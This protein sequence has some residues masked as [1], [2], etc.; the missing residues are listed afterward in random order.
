MK[1][2][3]PLRAIVALFVTFAVI[4]SVITAYFVREDI[5][6]INTQTL[7]KLS[8]ISKLIDDNYLYAVDDE[9]IANSLISGYVDGID[10]KYASYFDES[11]SATHNEKLKGESYGI[12]IMCV[13]EEYGDIF[14]WRVY[15]GSTAEKAGIKPHDLITEVG[16]KAVKKIGYA[17]ALS[18]LKSNKKG[19]KIDIKL[20]R[21]GKEWNVE[22]ATA[23]NTVQSVFSE[24]LDNGKIGYVYISTFN[25]KTYLQF[26]NAV[27]ELQNEGVKGL[28][29]DVRHNGGGT[30]GSAAKMLDFLL[31]KGD[32][33]MVMDKD[34]NTD[35]QYSSD[36]KCVNLP[37][38]VLGDGSSASASEIFISALKDVGGATFV[39]EKTYG[40]GVIQRTYYLDDGTS[41]KFTVAKFVNSKGESYHEKGIS[42]D[43][44]AKNGFKY[45][46]EFY[47]MQQ[48]DDAVLNKALSLF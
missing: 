39:G 43:V 21:D 47:Y 46:Y 38:V 34:G 5:A 2:K 6:H 48:S 28:I 40:K 26:K 16:G 45:D 32:T 20:L 4:V 12:G 30:V 3:I 9:T 44:T 33:V 22:V 42:P 13:A 29:I 24:K 35:V 31:P 17:K 11:D 36:K 18:M 25:N 1:T 10:D 27:S 15:S 7:N 23:K 37:I 41:V 8:E 19:K 14:V